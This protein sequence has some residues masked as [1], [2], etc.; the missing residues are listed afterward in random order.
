M[1]TLVEARGTAARQPRSNRS[2]LS[3]YGRVR[4]SCP[5]CGDAALRVHRR[6]VDRLYSLFHPIYRYQC[7]TLECG[8]QGNLPRTPVLDEDGLT[9]LSTPTG[10]D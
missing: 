1:E 7:T 9:P 3:R 8:W 4:R 5:L 2:M 6:V 10:S